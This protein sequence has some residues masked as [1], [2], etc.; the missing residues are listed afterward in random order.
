MLS[1]EEALLCFGQTVLSERCMNYAIEVGVFASISYFL[2]I[3]L[4]TLS[5]KLHSLKKYELALELDLFL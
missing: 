4:P 1:A 5:A 3:V 2:G